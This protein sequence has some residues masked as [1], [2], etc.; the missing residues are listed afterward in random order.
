LRVCNVNNRF[1]VGIDAEIERL[2]NL[3]NS[4]TKKSERIKIR[5]D[6]LMKIF[7]I[8]KMDTEFNKLSFHTSSSV[9]IID[10]GLLPAEYIKVKETKSPDKTAIKEAIKSGE[11]VP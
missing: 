10:E 9:E 2:T 11:T 8:D 7:G 3:K 6:Y 1:I 5:V 4:Y